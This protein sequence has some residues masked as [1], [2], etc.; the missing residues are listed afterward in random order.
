M[1]PDTRMTGKLPMRGPLVQ[2]FI[3]A[4]ILF[5]FW[6]WGPC[7]NPLNTNCFA[8]PGNGDHVQHFY[9]W[10]AYA[11]ESH[12]T[13]L[14]P[15]FNNWT[16]PQSSALIYGDTIPL[17]SLLLAP[18]LRATGVE[19]QYFSILSLISILGSFICGIW[20]GRHFGLQTYQCCLTG[21]ILALSPPAII[22]LQ[23][24]EALS[25]HVLIIFA[26]ALYIRNIKSLVIWC[27]LLGLASGTH[28]YYVPMILP[29]AILAQVATPNESEQRN[30]RFFVK[31]IASIE[32]ARKIAILSACTILWLVAFGYIPNNAQINPNSDI[33]SANILALLDPHSHS[34]FVKSLD[35][36]HPYQW[37]GFAYLGWSITTCIL[38][39]VGTTLRGKDHND[40]EKQSVFP[41][42]KLFGSLLA[43][44]FIFSLGDDW[45]AGHFRI[46][47]VPENLPLIHILQNTFRSTGRFMWP[48]YYSLTLWGLITLFRI[49]RINKFLIITIVLLLAESHLPASINTHKILAQHARQGENW[50]STMKAGNMSQLE[51]LLSRAELLYNAT[52]DPGFSSPSIPSFLPQALN[53]DIKT[54]YNP[55]LARLPKDFDWQN[56]G[57]PCML[58]ERALNTLENQFSPDRV[59]MIIPK[60]DAPN[61]KLVNS[62][63]HLDLSSNFP[64]AIYGIKR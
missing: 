46:F 8:A 10:L 7:W 11:K 29:I 31:R 4:L 51:Q 25:L 43:I 63:D 30:M 64:V 23:G 53:P 17:A 37:E 44:Y 58:A 32:M 54:N 56:Q 41:A 19:F 50:H 26:I 27:I 2:C 21:A 15:R 57:P 20:I 34:L 52:G 35:R 3:A 38:L 33:W 36:K 60:N 14:Q 18:I 48:V 22:R 13:W 16:W 5:W 59:Y 12:S 45:L 40:P 28:A 24:H 47:V 6:L 39:G 49:E 55:Y 1:F 61:C 42:P 9:A 62:E